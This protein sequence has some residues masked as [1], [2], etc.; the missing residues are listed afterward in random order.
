LT[1]HQDEKVVNYKTNPE[2]KGLCLT[3]K[4]HS[5]RMVVR[6]QRKESSTLCDLHLCPPPGGLDGGGATSSACTAN[7]KCHMCAYDWNKHGGATGATFITFL[8]KQFVETEHEDGHPWPL[9]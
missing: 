9:F 1:M 6:L 2:D 8:K 4:L 3:N 7:G 5:L